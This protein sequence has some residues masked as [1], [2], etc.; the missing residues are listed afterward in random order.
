M[1]NQ[2]S[3]KSGRKIEI[4]T[5][6]AARLLGQGL[7]T[8]AV[9]L[10]LTAFATAQ[11]PTVPPSPAVPSVPVEPGKEYRIGVGDE[12]EVAILLHPEL[13]KQ[14]K[15]EPDG[16]ITYLY[17]GRLTAAGLTM[18]QL[19][20]K[21]EKGLSKEIE[22]P[23]A[24]ITLLR[25]AEQMVSVLGNG[26]AGSGNRT[27][28]HGWRVLDLLTS[29]GFSTNAKPDLVTASIFRGNTVLPVDLE[30]LLLRNDLTQNLLLEPNDTLVI[31]MRDVSKTHINVQGEVVNKGWVPIPPDGSLRSLLTAAGG[32]TPM[33]KLSLA[34]I[35]RGGKT[36][37]IDLSKLNTDAD[38][39]LF[40]VQAGDMLFIPQN[41]KMYAVWGAV[42]DSK[43]LPYPDRVELTLLGAITS[44][45]GIRPDADLKNAKLLRGSATPNRL[46]EETKRA[47]FSETQAN[48]AG[49]VVSSALEATGT[50]LLLP[51][52]A[53]RSASKS[54]A[55]ALGAGVTDT[56]RTSNTQLLTA[57][58][59]SVIPVN[60]ED[61]LKR[62]D[63]SKDI[64]LLPGD[65]LYIPTKGPTRPGFGLMEAL[66]ILPLVSFMRF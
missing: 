49:A 8:A 37:P 3:T 15:V 42:A 16:R 6:Q 29:A 28:L 47:E 4:R 31:Q 54:A 61:I 33:A 14:V 44:A 52:N 38:A 53:D 2:K 58:R 9:S 41:Q 39:G 11:A 10:G 50:A 55:T 40:Q 21:I 30:A 5:K 27:L 59:D 26:L 1:L 25:R 48:L 19:A 45:G 7:L 57:S 60:L 23:K 17:I 46:E 65:V 12:L 62:K 51:G 24:N 35:S 20:A 18:A 63:L 64:A 32:T 34:K 56:F 22:E 13:S 66:G 43:L 36:I